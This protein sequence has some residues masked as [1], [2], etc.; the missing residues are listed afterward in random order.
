MVVTEQKTVAVKTFV[1]EELRNSFKAVCAKEGRNM[2][3]VLAEFVEQYVNKREA[4][5][6]SDTSSGG[7]NRGKGGRKD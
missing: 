5:P 6:T 7:K 4:P 2:S 3:D 1:S